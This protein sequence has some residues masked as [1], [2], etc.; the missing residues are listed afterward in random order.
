MTTIDVTVPSMGE[1]ITEGLLVEWLKKNGERVEVDEPLFVLETDKVTMTIN[2]EVSG[3]LSIAT[4]EGATVQIGQIVASIN[5]AA[6]SS[7]K[8]TGFQPKGGSETSSPDPSP[9]LH[10]PAGFPQAEAKLKTGHPLSPAVHRLLEEHGLHPEAIPPSG[11]DGRITKEDVLRF[12]EESRSDEIQGTPSLKEEQESPPITKVST[13]SRIAAP[14]QTRKKMTPLRSRIADR[15]VEA[16][17]AAA[18]LTT[19]NEADMS[20]VMEMRARH[21]ENFAKKHGVDLGFMSFFVKAVVDALKTVPELNAFIDGD[22]IVQ[23]HYYDIGIAIGGERGL[24]VPVIRDADVKSFAEIEQTISDFAERVKERTITLDEL[25]GGVFS[26]SNGGVFGS[27]LSTPILNP[28]QSGILGMH[29]IK[30]RPVVV[31]DAIE[32]RPMM[33]LALSYDHRLIDGRE[34]VAFLRRIVECIENPERMMLEL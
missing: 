13:P 25:Q 19:F 33:Y 12:L 1:S 14:R 11:K 34:S 22:E 21:R 23:N 15:M 6:S 16:Q 18:I 32:I 26:I 10:P 31:G 29:A 28:P 2:S 27:L 30:K 4:P 5:P 17:H 24:V 7:Q 3:L 8:V 20:R 9:P